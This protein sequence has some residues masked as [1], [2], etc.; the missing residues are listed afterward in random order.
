M[1]IRLLAL[2]DAMESNVFA[3]AVRSHDDISLCVLCTPGAIYCNFECRLGKFLSVVGN[4][5]RNFDCFAKLWKLLVN[6]AY[7]DGYK[8]GENSSLH[9]SLDAVNTDLKINA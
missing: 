6:V 5:Y 7:G 8:F 9:F 1:E 4:P 2:F 3:E